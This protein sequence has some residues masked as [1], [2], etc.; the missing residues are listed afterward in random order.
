MTA[1]LVANVSV[2]QCVPTM[3]ALIAQMTAEL[4][5]KLQGFLSIQAALTISPPALGAQLDGALSLVAQIQGQ[6]AAGLTVAPPGVNLSIAATAAAVAE[7]S[8]SLAALLALTVTLGTAGVSVIVH[9]GAA[10]THG[11]EM[12]AVVDDIAPPGNNV[13]SVTFLATAPEVWEA[14]GVALLTG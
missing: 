1:E 12:Q 3:A 10:S 9:E 11:P 6:L 7:L 14:L 13:H 8:A 2:G 4:T 5:G